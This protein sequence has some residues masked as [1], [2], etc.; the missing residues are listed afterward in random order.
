MYRPVYNLYRGMLN[1]PIVVGVSGDSYRN[2]LTVGAWF[3]LHSGNKVVWALLKTNETAKNLSKIKR[4]S[5]LY[6]DDLWILT[7]CA[8]SS[9]FTN[10]IERLNFTE[11]NGYIYHSSAKGYVFAD[12]IN[13]IEI[14]RYYILFG[15]IKERG[16][17]SVGGEV[18]CL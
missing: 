18:K 17:L 2:V 14:D 3:I 1:Y 7:E 4:F 10:K 16:N 5:F 11:V 15:E 8:R 12:L 6:I 9:R 13:T